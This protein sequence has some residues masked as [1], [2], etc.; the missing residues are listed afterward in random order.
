MDKR[1]NIIKDTLYN[2]MFLSNFKSSIFSLISN[3]II[4]G[5]E[6][7]TLITLLTIFKEFIIYYN[8]I[9]FYD[10]YMKYGDDF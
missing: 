9:L 2:E 6:L 10:R 3:I 8:W 1:F 5:Y 7:I 4:N